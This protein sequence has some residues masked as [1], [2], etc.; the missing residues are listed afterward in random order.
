MT[1]ESEYIRERFREL[2]QA[3]TEHAQRVED[4]VGDHAVRIAKL[5]MRADQTDATLRETRESHRW[6]VGTWISVV[7]VLIAAAGVIVAI[8]ALN[9]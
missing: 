9:Q 3:F 4:K 8:I 2:Q 1:D 7:S 5:E 6:S